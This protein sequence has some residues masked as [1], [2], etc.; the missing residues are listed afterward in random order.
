MGGTIEYV[1]PLKIEPRTLSKKGVLTATLDNDH[2][3]LLVD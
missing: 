2:D 1:V 3:R